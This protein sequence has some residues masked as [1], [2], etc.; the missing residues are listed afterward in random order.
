MDWPPSKE[1]DFFRESPDEDT[2]FCICLYWLL[3]FYIIIQAFRCLSFTGTT[4]ILTDTLA[5]LLFLSNVSQVH[6]QNNAT[7]LP[8]SSNMCKNA[9][10]YGRLL[11]KLAT[12]PK[13]LIQASLRQE[14]RTHLSVNPH[15][16]RNSAMR[17]RPLSAVIEILLRYPRYLRAA[18]NQHPNNR[19]IVRERLVEAADVSGGEEL[20][21]AGSW[22]AGGKAT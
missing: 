13:I 15:E 4:I 2:T 10:P 3:A 19:R 6:E 5:S 17:L 11:S 12:T 16:L 9:V 18:H 1:S 22:C 21:R 8:F 7:L 14:C 20:L